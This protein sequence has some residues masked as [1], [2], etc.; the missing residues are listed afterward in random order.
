MNGAPK[1]I[2]ILGGGVS[3]MSAAFELT[4]APD[5]QSK[6]DVTVYQMGWRLGGKG[7]SGRNAQYGQRIE[8]HGLHF[9]L[10]FY[11]NAFRMIRRCYEENARPLTEPLATWCEAFKPC[12]EIT[13]EDQVNGKWTPWLLRFPPNPDVPGDTLKLPSVWEM[14]GTAIE[15]LRNLHATSNLPESAGP[16]EHSV[17]GTLKHLWGS[18]KGEWDSLKLDAGAALLRGA[19]HHIKSTVADGTH[20]DAES[21]KF[22]IGVMD[23]YWNWLQKTIPPE[24]AGAFADE[25]WRRL[26]ILAEF[27]LANVRGIVADG[28]LIEGFSAIEQYDYK[29]WLGRH[30]AS[31]QVQNCGIV[32]AFY[33]LCFNPYGTVAAGTYLKGMLRILFTYRG[34]V[35][36]KMQ[37]G[38]GD[39][40]FAPLYEVLK[41]RGVKFKFF[42]KITGLHL[43]A[44]KRTIASIGINRQ[45]TM[46]SGEYKPF[47]PVRR[48]PCWPSEPLYDQLVEGEELRAK[49]V[50]LESYWA[51]WKG[52]D[53]APLEYG[54][55]FDTV[56]FGI[57]MGSVAI[58]CNEL[59]QARPEWRTMADNVRTMPTQSFQTWFNADVAGLGWVNWQN[60][61]PLVTAFTEPMDTFADMQHLLIREAWPSD[62]QPGTIGYFCGPMAVDPGIPTPAYHAFPKIQFDIVYQGAVQFMKDSCPAMLPKVI[63]ADGT[64][65]WSLLV[66]PDGGAGEERFRKQY[67]RANIDPSER[68]V[69]SEKGSTKFRLHS[70]ASGFDNLYLAGDW[71]DNG[72]NAGCVE[73]AVISGI[74]AADGIL[75]RP[76]TA[77][78]DGFWEK[79]KIGVSAGRGPRGLK[80]L[81]HCRF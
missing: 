14:L 1:R 69:L 45:A 75:K 32:R 72:V 3:A 15:F 17:A 77:I 19:E 54:K 50:N 13:V 42:Y 66:D 35:Y 67:F 48:L 78:G 37:A 11:E 36:W 21:H 68:Y 61:A 51:D 70:A 34:A 55:D 20:Q 8:E 16:E 59:I 79:L 24:P 58:L 6:Y 81:I 41:K 56:V 7:A 18:V 25:R 10:G 63:L 33:D 57:S 28:V 30:G 12:N 52:V 60:E 26:W 64:V 73:A 49:Q 65:N 31:E 46:K 40:I 23:S 74:Q 9:W 44:D 80:P 62:A 76:K 22:L 39:V 2:V 29:E 27:V 5:W 71:T 53:E 38:M 4:A 43:S 47:V